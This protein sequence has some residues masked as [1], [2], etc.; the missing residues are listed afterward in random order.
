MEHEPSKYEGNIT[1]SFYQIVETHKA[2]SARISELA[3]R[4]EYEYQEQDIQAL[5]V[6]AEMLEAHEQK[7][8]NE[9][10]TKVAEREA[11]VLDDKDALD[12]FLNGDTE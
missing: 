1:L 2:I 11:E 6:V 12:K 5:L 10:E 9:W 4:S 3:R 8:V 7:A